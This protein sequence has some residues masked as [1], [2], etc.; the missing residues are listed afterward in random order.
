MG[1]S[2]LVTWRGNRYSVMSGL[3]GANVLVRHRLGSDHLEIVSP[4]GI[5]LASHL[6]EPRSR[7]RHP[8]PR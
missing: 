3:E 1:D 5:M 8:A 4:L 7:W 2:S 6:R